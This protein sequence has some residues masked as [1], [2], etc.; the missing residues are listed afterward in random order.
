MYQLKEAHSERVDAKEALNKANKAE[1]S[2]DSTN[3]VI[4]KLSRFEIEDAYMIASE[5]GLALG[6]DTAV[7][8]R[9][10]KNLDSV[11][12]LISKDTCEQGKFKK[13]MTKLFEF[14]N[15]KK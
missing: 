14:R 11:N 9:L 12:H 2:I 7:A 5:S 15:H 1:H 6:G 8:N 3:L 10:T 4:Q 13:D